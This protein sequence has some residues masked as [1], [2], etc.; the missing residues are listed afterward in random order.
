VSALAATSSRVRGASRGAS[1]EHALKIVQAFAIVLFV[2]PSNFVIRPIGAIAYPAGLIGMFAMIVWIAAVLLGQHDTGRTKH[3]IRG[4]LAMFW[5]VTL[6]SYVLTNR[7]MLDASQSLAADRWLMQLAEMTGIAFLVAECLNSLDDV[8]RLLRVLT[9]ASAF[10]GVV[11][12]LQWRAGFN[13]EPYLGRIP[14]LT[15]DGMETLTTRDGLSRVAGTGIHPIELGVTAAMLLPIAIWAAK[16]TDVRNKARRWAPVLLTAI[17]VPASVARSGAIAVVCAF[18]MF[19]VLMPARERVT[20]FVLVPIVIV[21]VFA[22]SHGE[23][24]AF[25]GSFTGASSDT[26]V[27]HRTNNYPYVEHLVSQAPW[28]G[29]G[30]GTYQPDT[31][32]HILDNQYLTTAI[33]LGLIGVGALIC[34]FLFPI[35]IALKA[36]KKSHDPSLR[37]LCAALAGAALAGGICSAFFDSFSFPLFY[38]VYAITLGM[39][40]ACWRLAERESTE[41]QAAETRF[42]LASRPRDFPVFRTRRFVTPQWTLTHTEAD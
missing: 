8:R 15:D 12:L 17:S 36:R 40:G 42:G 3:P 10:C 41:E 37:L 27:T 20:A 4:V 21:A 18:G 30:G 19:L 11:A 7:G 14:G 31:G 26:S 22:T 38:N 28:L 33:E 1:R 16:H 5:L 39:I 9:W 29:T 34:F 25:V 13:L 35:L 2:I 24:G 6:A 32:L 23:L